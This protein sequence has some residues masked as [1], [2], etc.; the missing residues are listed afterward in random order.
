MDISALSSKK[1]ALY[2][3]LARRQGLGESADR[4]AAV[5]V[6][7]KRSDAAPLSFAQERLWL[8]HQLSPADPAYNEHFAARI[9]GRLDE[10]ALRS[11]LW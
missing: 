4:A 1:L 10:T 7:A 5:S 3:A 2:Q 9:A 8:L 6:M 11:S